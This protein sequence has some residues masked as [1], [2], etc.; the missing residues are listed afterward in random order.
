MP[1]Y[2][3]IPWPDAEPDWSKLECRGRAVTTPPTTSFFTAGAVARARGRAPGTWAR[4]SSSSIHDGV[5]HAFF[6][7]TRPEVYDEE[8]AKTAWRRT[9][10]FFKEKL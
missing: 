7:D 9:I 2:G 6:N 4:T 3:L 10:D 5:D 1:F 8:H